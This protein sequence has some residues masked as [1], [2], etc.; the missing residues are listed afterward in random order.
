[1][2]SENL[3]FTATFEPVST[4]SIVPV[5]SSDEKSGDVIYHQVPWY[6]TWV[7]HSIDLTVQMED[8]S[9]I[10]SVQWVYANWSAETP[11]A[12]ILYAGKTSA[13]IRPTWGIGARSC[14]VQAIVT[15]I[16]GNKITSDPVKVRFYNWD[17]QK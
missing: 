9:K 12:D 10:A 2:P 15:D 3:T 7:S 5:N 17:W 8:N 14:W 1:M 11:E 4:V 6:E 13:T 16:Y